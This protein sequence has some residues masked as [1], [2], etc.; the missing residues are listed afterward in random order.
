[1]KKPTQ[2][3]LIFSGGNLGT[4]ALSEIQE[5]DYLV[6]LETGAL[7][8]L[9]HD[10]TPDYVLGDF[11]SVTEAEKEYITTKCNH[12]ESCDPIDKDETDTEMALNWALQQNPKE[13][14]LLGV[15]GTRFDHSLANV[16]LLL[17]CW[18]TKIP[19]RIVDKHNQ[20]QLVGDASSLTIEKD[21]F[22]QVSLLPLT[23]EVSGITLQGF[24]YPLQDATLHIGKSLGI[25]NILQ[26]QE[27][28]I[29]VKLG[30]LLV[31]QSKD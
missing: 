13:I 16:H 23:S 7:F 2:R 24:Q 31:I 12:V 25:S 28:D 4:W 22:E 29:S 10:I 1:M 21:G 19:C 14:V 5:T 11:D 20:I 9:Q 8:L 18:Q 30:K 17:K 6:A 26:D 3:M 27:G 15:L